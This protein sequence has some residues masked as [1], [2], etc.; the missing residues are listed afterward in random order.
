MVAA[1]KDDGKMNVGILGFAHSHV[2]T[3]CGQWKL[4][5]DLGVAVVAGWDHDRPRLQAAAEQF[6]IDTAETAEALLAD[7]RL[8]A[9]VI[10][11]ET[12]EHAELVER[13][14]AAGKAVVLQ[15]PIAL[16]LEQADRIVAAV[17]TSG[18][19]FTMA[20]QMRV[21][22]QNLKMKDLV[23]RGQLGRIFMVRRRHG[24]STHLWDAFEDSWHV[25]AA[26]NRDIWADDA[27]HAADF[28]YWLLGVP[29]TVSAEIGTLLNPK[30]PNDNGIAVFRYADGAF[31]ELSC[32]FTCAAGENTTEIIAEK[33]VVIQNYGDAPSANCPRPAGGMGLK[34]YLT[35]TGTWTVAD[36]PEV[37]NH[38]ERIA[39][40]AK[41]LA[42]FL[43]GERP[44][45]ATAAE[46]RDVLR[47]ILATYES[48]ETGTRVRL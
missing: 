35:D 18:V 13:A 40:L 32:S 46:G 9:V 28:L 31:A 34:W 33:G 15:K 43:Q 17:E 41:P 3:Y 47:M 39:G 22:P 6:D 37:A 4:H 36:T 26:Y 45:I 19:P 30:I 23:D 48:N 1:G 44:P 20:W 16:T 14:A 25:D 21:D 29:Q 12:S 24:L 8:E 2:S 42:Q 10:A 38:G 5:P 27:S 11:A 7:A